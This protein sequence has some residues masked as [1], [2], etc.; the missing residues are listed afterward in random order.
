MTQLL[1]AI[2]LLLDMIKGMRAFDAVLAIQATIEIAQ[3]VYGIYKDM[4]DDGDVQSLAALPDVPLEIRLAM[5]KSSLESDEHVTAKWIPSKAML[6]I[7]L[8]KLFAW[9]SEQLQG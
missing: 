9:L 8:A 1:A 5:L 4:D 3:Y 7:L 2:S 6:K